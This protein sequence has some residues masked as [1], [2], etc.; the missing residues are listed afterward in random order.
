MTEF[1]FDPS[2]LRVDFSSEEAASE[3]RDFDPVPSGKYHVKIVEIELKACGPNSKNPG[4]PMWNVKMAIQEPN[5]YAGRNLWSNVML[6]AGAGYSLAQ[7][8]KA[9]GYEVSEGQI[10]VPPADD[11]IG[12]DLIVNVVKQVDT[13]KMEQDPGGDRLYKNEVKGFKAYDESE[14]TVGSSTGSAGGS[15]LP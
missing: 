8:M 4:K 1:D 13:Y 15:L 6:F 11:L 12:V 10:K 9:T 2:D 14:A 7:L 5:P 3:A